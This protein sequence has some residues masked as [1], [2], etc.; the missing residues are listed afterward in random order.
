MKKKK[1][2]KIIVIVIV[3]LLLTVFFLLLY[4]HYITPKINKYAYDI[5]EKFTY[6]ILDDEI[7]NKF[8]KNDL[9]NL[10]VFSKNKDDEILLIDYDVDKAYKINDKITKTLEKYLNG[11]EKGNVFLND[12]NILSANGGMMICVPFF[13][14]SSSVLLS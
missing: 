7:I 9:K 4:S 1:N 6:K 12:L 3:T 11:M 10:L 5:L 14:G 13:I 8:D 2:G